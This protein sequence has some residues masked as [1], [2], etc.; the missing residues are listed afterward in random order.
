[1]SSLQILKVVAELV[2]GY[3]CNQ[4]R[5]FNDLKKNLQLTTK[6]KICL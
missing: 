6:L 2:S 5:G 1:M 4:K 3:G